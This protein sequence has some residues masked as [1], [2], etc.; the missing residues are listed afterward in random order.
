[1]ESVWTVLKSGGVVMIPL[2]LC[3]VLVLAFSLSRLKFIKQIHG[4]FLDIESSLN[5]CNSLPEIDDRFFSNMFSKTALD[6][7]KQD[8]SQYIEEQVWKFDKSISKGLWFIGS[9]ATL[10]PFIGLFGTVLGIIKSFASMANAGKGGFAIVSA[11]LSEALIATAAGIFVAILASLA[12]NF[13]LQK[14][15]S[16]KK[17]LG[18]QLEK[19]YG[20]LER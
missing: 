12:Y 16:L 13:F 19:Y 8:L 20:V 15:A 14:I 7:S 3:S 1:M 11:D 2:V 18:F 4:L 5:S 10:S 6:A 9:I 17:D